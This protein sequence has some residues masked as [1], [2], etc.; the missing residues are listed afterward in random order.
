MN[1][2]DFLRTAGMAIAAMGI[3]PELVIWRPGEMVVVPARRVPLAS[4][5][6]GPGEMGEYFTRFQQF[7]ISN[8]GD[9]ARIVDIYEDTPDVHG[10]TI[11]DNLGRYTLPGGRYYVD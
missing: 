1:R 7:L 3:D 10:Q 2:R 8:P 4:V 11:M 6:L 9:T 5:M